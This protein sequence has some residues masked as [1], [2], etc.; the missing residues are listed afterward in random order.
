MQFLPEMNVGREVE[1]MAE[2]VDQV[3]EALNGTSGTDLSNVRAE[4]MSRLLNR[5]NHQIST[6]PPIPV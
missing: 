6:I 3:L 4:H 2:E 5:F 1:V